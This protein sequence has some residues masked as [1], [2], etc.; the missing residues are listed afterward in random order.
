[1]VKLGEE[2]MAGRV[3]APEVS[4]PADNFSSDSVS[5][6]LPGSS[7]CKLMMLA[8]KQLLMSCHCTECAKLLSEDISLTA[9]SAPRTWRQGHHLCIWAAVYAY[10]EEQ[11]VVYMHLDRL[12]IRVS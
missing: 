4:P 6:N 2:G 1:M 5:L 12:W 3:L 11:F 10:V 9:R 8:C 7:D